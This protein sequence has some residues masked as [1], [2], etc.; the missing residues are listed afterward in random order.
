M[1]P[2][3]EFDLGSPLAVKL[4]SHQPQQHLTPRIS[5]FTNKPTAKLT[6]LQI[7]FSLGLTVAILH[8]LINKQLQMNLGDYFISL[9][10]SFLLAVMFCVQLF[11]TDSVGARLIGDS[12]KEQHEIVRYLDLFAVIVKIKYYCSRQGAEIVVTVK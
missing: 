7:K 4:I 9:T 8:N 12:N 10:Y 11:N 3:A 5:W 2:K 1:G 6:I